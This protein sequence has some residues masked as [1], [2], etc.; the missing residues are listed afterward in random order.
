MAAML[1]LEKENQ[2]RLENLDLLKGQLNGLRG[3]NRKRDE[4]FHTFQK[5]IIKLLFGR[6]IWKKVQQIGKLILEIVV[7]GR[8]MMW[9]VYVRRK[10]IR[11]T[12][13]NICLVLGR[14]VVLLMVVLKEEVLEFIHCNWRKAKTS[15]SSFLIISVAYIN[16]V[17]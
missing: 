12:P 14:V 11:N 1:R 5:L 9:K 15:V 2:I 8:W 13:I 17:K 4:E 10:R 7:Q 16:V 6:G 3:D